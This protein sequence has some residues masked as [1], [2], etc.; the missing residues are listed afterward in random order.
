[1]SSRDAAGSLAGWKAEIVGIDISDS[2]I[3][4]AENGQYSQF[5]IQRGLPV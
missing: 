4:T 1:M 3:A 2:A 5:D